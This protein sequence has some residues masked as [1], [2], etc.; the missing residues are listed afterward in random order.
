MSTKHMRSWALSIAFATIT[1]QTASAVTLNLN[2]FSGSTIPY[3]P[4]YTMTAYTPFAI[5]AI[6]NTFTTAFNNWNNA[7]VVN[8]GGGGLWKIFN[9]GALTGTFTVNQYLPTLAGAHGDLEFDMSY[10]PGAGDPAIGGNTVWCQAINTNAKLAGSLPGNPMYLDGSN[11]GGFRPPAYPYQYNDGSFYDDPSRNGVPGQTITWVADLYQTVI[12]YRARKLYVY[13]GVEWGFQI[14]GK[15]NN[16][17]APEPAPIAALGLGV[18]A[19][20]IR[21]RKPKL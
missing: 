7:A 15:L 8:G 16:N 10:T 4:N 13:D 6:S 14:T 21:R 12:D 18:L 19:M 17:G 20:V 3:N 2:G 1:F 5:A 9:A 11:A